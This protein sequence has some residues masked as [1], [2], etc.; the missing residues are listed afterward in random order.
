MPKLPQKQLKQ[1]LTV[2]IDSELLSTIKKLAKA[3]KLT[4]REIVE[5]GFNVYIEEANKP[6]MRHHHNCDCGVCRPR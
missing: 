5:F 6:V 2:E 1:S 3:N 4:L